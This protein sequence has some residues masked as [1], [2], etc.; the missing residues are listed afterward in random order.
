MT[1]NTSKTGEKQSVKLPV[2]IAAAFVLVIV[3]V[4]IWH[5][6]FA[7][8]QSGPTAEGQS[9]DDFIKAMALQAGPNADMTKLKPADK[10]KL[11]G[12]LA[13]APIPEDQ[14]LKSIYNANQPK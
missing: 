3:L 5:K 6:V 9:K 10:E 1:A 11:D 7:P 8:V 4:F 12:Y 14:L 2:I 13:H